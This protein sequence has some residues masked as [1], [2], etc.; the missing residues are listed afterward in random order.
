MILA[1]RAPNSTDAMLLVQALEAAGVA[2]VQAGGQGT[3]ALGELPADVL[4]IEIWVP[5]DKAE[6]ARKTIEGVQRQDRPTVPEW[7][8]AG[9]GETNE[10][11]F[12][13]CW[14]CQVPRATG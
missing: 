14:S 12:E 3:I 1:Y 10:G 6:L 9:C 2:T 8:C 13:L 7:S 5:F 11:A 4:L